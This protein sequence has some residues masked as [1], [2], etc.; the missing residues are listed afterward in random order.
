LFSAQRASSHH[1]EDCDFCF[2]EK[3]QSGHRLG[4]DQEITTP[5]IEATMVTFLS[6]KPFCSRTLAS[7]KCS[8]KL[9]IF[10]IKGHLRVNSKRWE[11]TFIFLH[12]WGSNPGPHTSRQVLYSELHPSPRKCFYKKMVI[13]KLIII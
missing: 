2:L 10:Y 9:Q 12:H 8:V 6:I 5:S 3:P 11:S 1:A 13:M 4:N 7:F